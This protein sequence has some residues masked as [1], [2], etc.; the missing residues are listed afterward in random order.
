MS[1]A[2]YQALGVLISD[3]IGLTSVLS[4]W[5]GEDP[6]TLQQ[7]SN[8]QRVFNAVTGVMELIAT[9]M[10]I[11][12]G[13]SFFRGPCGGYVFRRCFTGDTEVVLYEADQAET[14]AFNAQPQAPAKVA[15][16]LPPTDLPKSL[17]ATF[18]ESLLPPGSRF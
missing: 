3:S 17:W 13:V 9:G 15:G 16:S 4:A 7:L 5:W 8:T 6:V 2:I 18:S 12:R 11:Y 10:G 14:I 1:S